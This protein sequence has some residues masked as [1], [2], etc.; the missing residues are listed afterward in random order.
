MLHHLPFFPSLSAFLVKGS[1]YERFF[2]FS[3]L[4]FSLLPDANFLYLSRRHQRAVNLLD[5]G[6]FTHAGFIVITGEVGAGK[7][8]IV[9]RMIKNAP[10]D[11][12]IGLITNPSPAIGSL[13]QW[14]VSSFAIKTSASDDAGLYQAFVDFL[15]AAY[16]KGKRAVL[17]L[18]EAQNLTPPLLEQLRMLSNIN[19]EKDQIL[20]IVLV[21]QPELLATLRRPEL[22]QFLQRVAVHC[23]LDA[24]SLKE[25]FGYIRHRIHLVG[26]DP[27]L[28][29]SEA[30]AAVH[31]FTGGV[32]RLI[33]LLCDQALV[34]AFSGEERAVSFDTVCE[35]ATDRDAM[36]LSA[37]KPLPEGGFDVL[38]DQ[39]GLAL[40]ALE[41]K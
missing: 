18:D 31:Y 29:D 2:G 25:T 6:L 41:Q 36:G 37:F 19:N 24:L 32:P 35:V 27:D 40:D 9:R 4:P 3:A 26:G 15:L 21:G 16:A 38:W 33:N 30:V 39:V 11:L 12:L 7:T 17:I 28:F 23:H 10:S 14:V 22:R 8:T 5:Y 34:Y 13:L 1:M 20:E